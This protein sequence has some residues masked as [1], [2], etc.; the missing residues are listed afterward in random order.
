MQTVTA[1]AQAMADVLE[2]ALPEIDAVALNNYLPAVDSTRVA[3]VGA[4]TGSRGTL[5]PLTLDGAQ[6]E[7]EHRVRLQLWVKVEQGDADA[8]MALARDVGARALLALAAGDGGGYSLAMEDVPLE[9]DV[10]PDLLVV[11][12]VPYVLVNLTATVWETGEVT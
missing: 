12:D 9:S 3:L 11:G 4:P 1:L 10:A 6:W 2:A 5:R 7:A 8:S